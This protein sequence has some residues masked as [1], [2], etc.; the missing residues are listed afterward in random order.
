MWRTYLVLQVKCLLRQSRSSVIIPCRCVLDSLLPLDGVAFAGKRQRLRPAQSSSPVF[1]QLQ[2]FERLSGRFPP[3]LSPMR[4]IDGR[5]ARLDL[6]ILPGWT[7]YRVDRHSASVRRGPTTNSLD[8]FGCA[9]FTIP[10]RLRHTASNFKP[11]GAIEEIVNL[12]FSKYI[13]FSLPTFSIDWLI[14]WTDWS[15]FTLRALFDWTEVIR[16]PELKVAVDF[17]LF[18]ECR[19]YPD[20]LTSLLSFVVLVD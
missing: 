19:H 18:S 2:L 14:W 10:L 15:Y 5:A 20:I 11:S 4:R 8:S 6:T 12:L 13:Y 1:H 9:F 3:V 17:V 16:N 7:V